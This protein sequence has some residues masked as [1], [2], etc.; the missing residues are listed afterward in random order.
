M[1]D[2]LERIELYGLV[3]EIRKN[4]LK[5]WA[6]Y[7]KLRAARLVCDENDMLIQSQ[8]LRRVDLII[9][10]GDPTI[11][12][13]ANRLALPA[14][15][16]VVRF[17][18]L[19]VGSIYRKIESP[20]TC[21]VKLNDYRASLLQQHVLGMRHEKLVALWRIDKWLRKNHSM[22]LERLYHPSRPMAKRVVDSAYTLGSTAI[23]A[24]SGKNKVLKKIKE[25]RVEV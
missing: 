8:K 5:T 25:D 10:S 6:L 20:E 7:D 15:C 16:E 19:P 2:K 4:E 14:L 22:I 13:L 21:N 18:E 23:K 17:T 1:L 12:T 11:E 3:Q 9:K 24:S